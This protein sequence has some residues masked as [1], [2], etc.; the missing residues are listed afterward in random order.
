E[1]GRPQQVVE[2][3]AAVAGAL[4]IGLLAYALSESDDDDDCDDGYGPGR[5]SH[6]SRY[7]RRYCD[8]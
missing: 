7:S 8:Y 1:Y 5:Y 6:R 2:P 3:G 4:A